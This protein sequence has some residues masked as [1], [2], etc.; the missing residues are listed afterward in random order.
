MLNKFKAVALAFA[1]GC[2]NSGSA[3]E[4][5]YTFAG[6]LNNDFGTYPI[7]TSYTGYLIYD[8]TQNPLD[9]ANL[10]RGDYSYRELSVSIGGE[11][12]TDYGTGVV[13]IYNHNID[14]PSDENS[15]PTDLMHVYAFAISGTLGGVD[16]APGA[17]LQLVLQ[18]SAGTVFNDLSIPKGDLSLS[19][20]TLG[21]ATH[22]QLQGGFNAE[23]PLF[24]TPMARGNLTSFMQETDVVTVGATITISPS[25]LACQPSSE[26][27][28]GSKSLRYTKYGLNN[29]DRSKTLT[30]RCPV[31]LDG[32]TVGYKY[33]YD[34]HL[35]TKGIT[36]SAAGQLKCALTEVASTNRTKKQIQVRSAD[37]TGTSAKSLDWLGV[38]KLA[39][40]G[41]SAFTLEC[42][43]PP[44]VG[45]A[46]ITVKR[47]Q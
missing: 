46:N 33:T 17:G 11:T 24:E 42:K 13:N 44:K 40:N 10:G 45:L 39:V 7:G 43:V 1:L 21:D 23:D 38:A 15:Y 36:K 31:N 16:L 3:E 9:P 12:A 25:T 27:N 29:V 22:I 20:F 2:S 37:I 4:L 28:D 5:T 18:D 30:V 32:E 19:K 26:Q 6:Q 47:K 34:I 14:N 8:D 41:G 35:I